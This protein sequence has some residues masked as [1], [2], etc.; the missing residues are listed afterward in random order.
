MVKYCA[1]SDKSLKEVPFDQ[2]FQPQEVA[3]AIPELGVFGVMSMVGESLQA[4]SNEAFLQLADSW[5]KAGVWVNFY[6]WQLSDMAA[7]AGVG[8]FMVP[9]MRAILS[10]SEI[11]ESKFKNWCAAH[12]YVCACLATLVLAELGEG[13]QVL[14]EAVPTEHQLDVLVLAVG[15]TLPFVARGIQSLVQTD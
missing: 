2:I 10:D 5:L 7:A 9:V 8:V 12:T 4:M 13:L 1:M 11:G 14:T 6:R 3:A 15:T